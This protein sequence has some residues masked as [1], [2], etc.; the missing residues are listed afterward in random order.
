MASDARLLYRSRHVTLPSVPWLSAEALRWRRFGNQGVLL[1]FDSGEIAL[2]W[3][4]AIN[5]SPLDA[6]ARPGWR[7]VLVESTMS[8]GA[9]IEAISVLPLDAV[10]EREANEVTI[11]VTYNGADLDDVAA[12]V[13]MSP[14]E[15]I[16]RHCA[17][18]YTVVCLGFSRAFPYLSGLDPHLWLP[19][20]DTP[21][22]G[23][24]GGSVAIAVDQAGIY[25]QTSPGGWHL[26]GHTSAVLFDPSCDQPS[27]LH[28]GDHGRFVRLSA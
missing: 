17:A 20:H 9:L 5:E 25:P 19:R 18:T 23:V 10:A 22:V 11:E 6:R 1:D 26:L 2:R 16:A 8:S 14:E 28:P 7:S 24:P 12:A 3:C 27:L 13:L 15:V 21:R 4:R